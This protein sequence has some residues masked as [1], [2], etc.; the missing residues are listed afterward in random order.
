MPKA[1]HH[2]EKFLAKHSRAYHN[3]AARGPADPP[4]PGRDLGG[5]AEKEH[6]RAIFHQNLQKIDERNA[7]EH[8]TNPRADRAIHG[9]TKYADWAENEF[10]ALL[11]FKTS[12]KL[13][14]PKKLTAI[15]QTA[16]QS[17]G[18]D[19]AP[20]CNTKWAS[21]GEVRDQGQCGD[22]WAFSTVEQIRSSHI[23][24]HGMDPGRLSTQFLV[25]CVRQTTCHGGVNGCCGGDPG[26]A[27][28][29]IESQGGIPT[30]AAYGD[31]LASLAQLNSS[32]PVSPNPRGITLSGNNPETAYPCKA[33]IPKAV[34]VTGK[35]H[36]K[37]ETEMA[38]HVCQTGSLSIILDASS[39]QTYKSGVI[40]AHSC[41]TSV[42]HAVQVIGLNTA[43]NAWIVQNSWGPDWGVAVDGGLASED[44][45]S[46]CGDLA[47]HGCSDEI[48]DVCPVSCGTGNGKTGGYVYMAYGANTCGITA[49]P[50]T[51]DTAPVQAGDVYK[52]VGWPV[53]GWGGKCR[54]P[55]G[56]VY[57]VGDNN[58]ACKS[59]AC[60]GGEVVQACAEGVISSEHAGWKVTCADKYE[61][62]GEPQ[63]GSWGG[64]CQ[65]PSGAIYEVGDNHDSCG[66]LACVGGKVVGACGQGFISSQREG[67][68][69]TCR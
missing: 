21:R 44:E 4:S 14:G 6:R 41:G 5:D 40:K 56:T 39:W 55:S 43:S 36:L 34:T 66:S 61:Y 35:V 10:R 29:W 50:V 7:N 1:D 18:I 2:F 23:Q 8:A 31:I 32:G 69:V 25:D 57:E 42:D 45:Y 11:G 58:D 17:S 30:Q 3:G 64:K 67:W 33:N 13:E 26:E 37:S 24:Q 9:I 38:S 19:R 52:H 20:P 62:V 49:S 59:I 27:M 65:C 51:A 12:H 60:I 63:V 47:K 16:Q 22:C 15:E 48:K 53:G 46:N 54:C 28:N 68:R